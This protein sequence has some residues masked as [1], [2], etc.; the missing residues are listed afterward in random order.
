MSNLSDLKAALIVKANELTDALDKT[1]CLVNIDTWYDLRSSLDVFLSSGVQ[2]YSHAGR[3]FTHINATDFAQQ[4]ESL[5]A[6][7]KD[8]L[9]GTST[10][11]ADDRYQR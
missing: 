6:T 5:Y 10:M 3:T 9:Y 1:E 7:I 2:S 4:A 11:L 8:Q